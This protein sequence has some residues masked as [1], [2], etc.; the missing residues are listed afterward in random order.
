MERA[1]VRRAKDRC[2][3]DCGDENVNGWT[4][5]LHVTLN[6]DEP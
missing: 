4:A 3:M 5:R 1:D 6:V 2:A